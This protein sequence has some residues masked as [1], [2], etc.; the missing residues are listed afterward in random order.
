MIQTPGSVRAKD[1][2]WDNPIRGTARGLEIAW[3]FDIGA[4]LQILGPYRGYVGGILLCRKRTL[5]RGEMGHHQATYFPTAQG[6]G[7]LCE[8]YWPRVQSLPPADGRDMEERSG[9]RDFS[10]ETSRCSSSPRPSPAAGKGCRTIRAV[11]AMQPV[12]LSLGTGVR[13]LPGKFEGQR[14][15]GAARA[16]ERRTHRP[17][18]VFHGGMG[19]QR[20]GYP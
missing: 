9:I 11:L 6:R 17:G 5:T 1:R 4:G 16:A 15:A 19:G 12:P 7:Q 2:D 13:H 10:T 8:L 14:P 20:R 3:Q 18:A